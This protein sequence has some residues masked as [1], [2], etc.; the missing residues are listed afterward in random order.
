MAK[1]GDDMFLRLNSCDPLEEEMKKLDTR[2]D[3][4]SEDGDDI[5]LVISH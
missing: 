3:L 5:T 1:K 4:D 2:D